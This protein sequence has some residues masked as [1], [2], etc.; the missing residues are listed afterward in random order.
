M[1]KHRSQVASQATT[2]ALELPSL[3]AL[4]AQFG[5]T[6]VGR[7]RI[8]ALE[9]L[10]KRSE[11]EHRQALVRDTWKVLK[12]GALVPSQEEA[13]LPLLMGLGDRQPTVAGLQLL[14]LA[15]V[16]GITR[17][18]AIRVASSDL[19][20]PKLQQLLADLPD[21]ESLRRRITRSLD[22]R[23]RVKD[24]ASPQLV[25]LRRQV[26]GVRDGLYKELKRTLAEGAENFA[27]DT[28]SLK[29]GRLTLLLQANARG[30]T[31]GLV[32]GKSGTGQSL[33]FE[34][35]ESVEGNNRLQESLEE[36]EA[37]R[38]RI[39][40]ELYNEARRALP[41]IE[42]HFGILGELDLLQAI[43]R[44]ADRSEALLPEIGNPGE[45]KLIAARHP[46]L[47]P[48]L[49]DLREA[50]LGQAGHQEA[51]VPLD[52]VLDQTQRILVITGPNAGGKT[53]ALKTAGLLALAAQCGLP[54]PAAAGTLLPFS[55][56]VMAM[57]GD[58]QDL[59]NDRSTFS[60]RLLRLKEAWEVAGQDSLVLLDEVGSGT[61]PEEGSA[62]AVALLEGL[63]DSGTLGVLT[64][65][66]TQLAAVA[67]ERSGASCAAME[68][69][70]DSGAPTY[71]LRPGA[72]G[73]SQALALAERLGLPAVWLQ[74]ADAL[75]G[76][77]HR[78]LRSLLAEVEEVRRALA[79]TQ[80][81]LEAEARDLETH[82]RRL[83][84]E[85]RA[86]AEERRRLAPRMKAELEAF[87][88]EVT[89]KLRAEQ[90]LLQQEVSRGRRKGLVSAGVSRLFEDAPEIEAEKTAT[91]AVEVGGTVRHAALGWTGRLDKIQGG[92]AEV[93]VHGKRLKCG[94]DD[95]LAVRENVGKRSGRLPKVELTRG[96]L[97]EV[98]LPAELKLVG[99]RVEPAL[100]TL[101]R[102]LDQALL[103]SRQQV[104]IVH[105]FGSGRLRRAVREHMS[106]HPAVAGFRPG[107]KNEGGDG[108]T[109]V[110]LNK[111]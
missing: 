79:E 32:H 94:V 21:V 71:H 8:L 98:D 58:E 26:H 27:S 37:E 109:V 64:T 65:H 88:S 33:Y 3:L 35:L 46:L 25:K 55:A 38:Q 81:N 82:R 93:L 87:R 68:F 90:E 19:E 56:A 11:V 45:L 108:A 97:A 30:R 42:I 16:L 110:T 89:R 52:L 62:L 2:Q 73:G 100:E 63:L 101:D 76:Q 107:E 92:T 41:E 5:A 4:C 29:D 47:D 86:A 60:A 24:D 1:T 9:P 39:I 7:S 85:L 40:A 51:A 48:Q 103:S 70:P 12:D 106:S 34:P 43:C 28:I 49:A 66:L 67:L 99:I 80:A 15:T 77:E 74:R 10:T 50:A 69:D 54:I 44:F 53:V 96:S 75:L 111:T 31:R 18:A 102:Y 83:A 22:R 13:L 95:L 61:D 6:D 91:G 84:E 57:V 78:D 14:Q 105:G 59:L 17:Q 72:P 20:I 104:R 36:E 23:G